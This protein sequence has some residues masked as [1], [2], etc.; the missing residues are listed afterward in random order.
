V[1]AIGRRVDSLFA[2][3]PWR[4]H[5]R[6]SA[7]RR[8]SPQRRKSPALRAPS[9][10]IVRLLRGQK[11]NLRTDSPNTSRANHGSKVRSAVRGANPHRHRVR[12]QCAAERPPPVPRRHELRGWK[13]GAALQKLKSAAGQR[14][15]R[16]RTIACKKLLVPHSMRRAESQLRTRASWALRQPGARAQSKR[17]TDDA[18]QSHTLPPLP[19]PTLAGTGECCPCCGHAMRRS[20]FGISSALE[21]VIIWDECTARE[22][23]YQQGRQDFSR[24]VRGCCQGRTHQVASVLQYG[25]APLGAQLFHFRIASW[26]PSLPL[27]L[28]TPLTPP[29]DPLSGEA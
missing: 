19:S 23:R 2:T 22:D 17:A 18:P 8:L 24:G 7:L 29:A 15:C 5:R 20:R 11:R 3:V 13:V 4:R 1:R 12:A 28:P 21:P 14:G 6:T 27:S 26:G 10:S 16:T 9:G 25:C